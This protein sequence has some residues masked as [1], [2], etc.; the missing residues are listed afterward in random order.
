M[1][2]RCRVCDDQNASKHYGS[3]CCSGCKGFFRR[4]IKFKR[5]YRCQYSK[6]CTISPEYR[7]S[8][9]ACRFEKCLESGLDPNMVHDDRGIVNAKTFKAEMEEKT[10]KHKKIKQEIVD[11][12]ASEEKLS[13]SSKSIKFE[14]LQFSEDYDSSSHALM[15]YSN[16]KQKFEKECQK[17]HELIVATSKRMFKANSG[18]LGAVRIIPEFD[19]S[20]ALSI[21]N[22]FVLVEK[23]CDEYF[24]CNA[25]HTISPKSE[26]SHSTEVCASRALSEP[27]EISARTRVI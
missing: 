8:C 12:D 10:A 5:I 23:L 3:L 27:R 6:N 11:I 16:V 13:S 21:A 14:G 4:T 1:L 19:K 7:N 9:R 17:W 15:E 24:D 25:V 18:P 20:N 26:Y 22:Y 2:Q